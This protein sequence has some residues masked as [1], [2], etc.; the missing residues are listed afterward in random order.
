MKN[1]IRYQIGL[2]FITIGGIFIISIFLMFKAID[3]NSKDAIIINLAGRQRMLTQK[4]TKEA[5]GVAKGVISP[6]KLNQTAELFDRT[7]R[8]LMYGNNQL[9][10]CD[11]PKILKQLKYVKSLWDP[12]YNNVKLLEENSQS[13]EA[14]K[15][16]IDNNLQILN[17]MN[18][19]VNLFEENSSANLSNIKTYAIIIGILTI[20]TIF[21]ILLSSK[22]KIIEPIE[23]LTVAAKQ[24]SQ[25]NLNIELG[26]KY[27]TEFD[28]LGKAFEELAKSIKNYQDKLIAEKESIQQKV[29]QAVEKARKENKYLSESVDRIVNIMEQV[30]R[31]D[32][33]VS[34]EILEEDNANIKRLF[35]SFNQLISKIKAILTD[36]TEAV[37][38]TASASAQISSSAEEMAAGAKQQSMQTAEVASA[39][40]EMTKT[41]L[42][43]AKNT[44]NAVVASKESSATA[45]EGEEKI[46]ETK[47]GM[48]NILEVT[49]GIAGV[50][51]NLN[52]KADQIGEITQIIDEIAEQTNL[53]AL[54]A[55]IEAA[56]AGEHGRGFAVVA[57]EVRKL[58][59][60]TTKATKEIAETIQAIQLE[61]KNATNSMKTAEEVVNRGTQLADEIERVFKQIIVS[62]ENTVMEINQVAA[63]SEQQS[64]TAEQISGSMEAINNVVNE[65]SMGIEQI[66]RASEDLQRLT[67]NLNELVSDF[68]LDS[69]NS[70]SSDFEVRANGKMVPDLN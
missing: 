45:K 64:S 66:A 30:S 15:N 14:L 40:E 58:A 2:L 20:L 11:D 61:S 56:R 24:I 52:K 43:T 22:K 48:Q 29:D 1:K 57:D 26:F 42:E 23:K 8:G 44:N 70:Q 60:R 38:A 46:M 36:V 17:E 3:K 21:F 47:N 9:P 49:N 12:F 19:A 54:N 4:M 10:A 35:N 62:I 69:N 55:A 18:K 34:V 13:K 33:T 63:A 59:E 41:I 65:T 67:E 39:V 53:L 6:E 7:L 32:L 31:G 68:K 25:G 5:I 28:D 50:I 51:A 16:L 27:G 37:Q